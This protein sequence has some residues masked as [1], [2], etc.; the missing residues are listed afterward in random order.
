LLPKPNRLGYTVNVHN[1]AENATGGQPSG[2]KDICGKVVNASAGK[3]EVA[4]CFL[5]SQLSGPYWVVAFD[6]KAGWALVSGGPPDI[7][8]PQGTT[9]RT[10]TGVNGSGLWIFT[11]QQKRDK[12]VVDLVRKK[13]AEKGFDL[14]V[15]L[16]INQEKCSTTVSADQ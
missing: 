9:C 5:P 16:D 15:L 2:P 1:H 8:G 6:K 13:A 3:L 7:T 11:R 14:S 12:K 4:P 10:G